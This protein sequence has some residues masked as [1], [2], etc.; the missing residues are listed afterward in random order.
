MTVTAVRTRDPNGR[1]LTFTWVLL[2]GDPDRVRITP[3]DAQGFTARIAVDW[4]DAGPV[5]PRDPR[6]TSRVDIGVFASNGRQDSAPAFLSITFPTH[7]ARRYAPGPEGVPRLAEVDYDARGR[8]Q[9]FDRLL[10][11]SA[12]WRDLFRHGPDGALLGW[13]RVGTDSTVVEGLGAFGADGQLTEGGHVDY[14]LSPPHPG[15]TGE[16][17]LAMRVTRKMPATPPTP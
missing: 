9:K 10:Y 4:Q 12:P 13:T 11:W 2:R 7:E 15:P 16:P 5:S 1:P 17:T 8:G 14:M 3:Y 6:L